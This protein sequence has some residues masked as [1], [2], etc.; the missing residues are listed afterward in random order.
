MIDFKKIPKVE[1]HL[2]LDGSIRKSTLNDFYQK[3]VTSEIVAKDKC[4]DLKEY[5]TKF[6]LPVAFLQTKEN[7]RRACLELSE[8]LENDGVIYAEVRF[9]PNLHTSILTLEEV[10]ET[11]I[12]SFKCGHLKIGVILCMTRN[13]SF[14][15]NLKIINL[16]SKYLNRGVVAID[17]AGDEANYKTS[18]FENLFQKASENNIPFTI[19]A[20]EVN[21]KESI[22]SALNLKPKRLGHGIAVINY[23][24]LLK[25]VVDEKI[26]LEICPTSNVQTNIVAKYSNHPIKKLKNSGCLISI[27]TDNRTVSNIT[28][29]EEYQKLAQT[30]NFTIKDFCQ[31]NINA[32][33]YSWLTE[34][35]K[36]EKIKLITE[37]LKINS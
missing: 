25:R 28:L 22:K 32:I 12:D 6:S 19:H 11:V 27:N 17:L 2:H 36:Q 24:D 20:G 13:N 9:A 18:L 23:Q 4:L 10:V 5:L 21:Q 3:D 34:I 1:L 29:S 37:Y 35:E 31:F 15:N 16:A 8:D 7:L 30:F 26:L 33:N 14:D